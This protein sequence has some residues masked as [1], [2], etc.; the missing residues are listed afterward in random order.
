MGTILGMAMSRLPRILDDA[1]LNS[2]FWFDLEVVP[3]IVRTEPGKQTVGNRRK[4]MLFVVVTKRIPE[5][6]VMVVRFPPSK[7]GN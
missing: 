4:V 3:R 6:L 1:C 2:S 7:S 5:K